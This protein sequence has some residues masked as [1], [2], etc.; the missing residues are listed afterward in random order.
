MNANRFELI[1]STER[2]HFCEYKTTF[3]FAL[4]A[5]QR[6]RVLNFI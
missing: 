1:P 4:F 2:P 6:Q 5:K 3:N